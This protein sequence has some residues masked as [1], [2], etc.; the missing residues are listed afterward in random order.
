[1][2][3]EAS[4]FLTIRQSHELI[5][6]LLAEQDNFDVQI[7]VLPSTALHSSSNEIL[8]MIQILGSVSSVAGFIY[9][10]RSKIKDTLNMRFP[11]G[12]EIKLTTTKQID[13]GDI[14]K[15]IKEY[16]KG[17]KNT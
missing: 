1:M 9:S 12:T 10:I 2:Q 5:D 14:T 17:S 11:N 13:V 4:V 16:N 7:N 15:I 8:L 6:D 3:N